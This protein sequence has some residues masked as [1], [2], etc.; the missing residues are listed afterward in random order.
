MFV[1][2]AYDLPGGTHK[3]FAVNSM[4]VRLVE[5]YLADTEEGETRDTIMVWLGADHTDNVKIWVAAGRG[6]R[7]YLELVNRLASAAALEREETFS[8]IAF[9]ESK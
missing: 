4:K 2:L 5:L 1:R 3:T 8:F 7:V 9:P 6:W